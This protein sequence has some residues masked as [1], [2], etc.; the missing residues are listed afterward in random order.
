MAHDFVKIEFDGE[1][2]DAVYSDLVRLEVELDDELAAMFRLRVSMIQTAEG[3][4]SLDDER[5]CIWAPVLITAGFGDDNQELLSGYITHVKPSFGANVEQ[6]YLDV[7]GMD[8][9]VLMDR[10]ENLK[11]W[12]DKTD[13]AIASEIFE[14]YGLDAEVEDTTV[15]H[16]KDAGTTIQ[17]ETDLQ[18]LKRLALR[19]GYEC[20]VQG[21]TGYFK[22]P[23]IDEEPQPVLAVHFGDQTNIHNFSLQVDALAPVNVG[24]F[25]I[26]RLNKEVLSVNVESS[27]QTPLGES[28]A[29]AFLASDMDRGQIYVGRNGATE[30]TEMQALCQGLFHQAEWFVTAHGEVSANHYEH[31]LTPRKTVTVKGVGE[32]YSGVYFVNHVTHVFTSGGYTQLVKMKRNALLPTGAEDFGD[33][34]GLLG[35]L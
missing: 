33:S 14:A 16:D 6:A 11:D 8:A 13:S 21:T 24:M 22:A 2:I 19:N 28:D 25:Q 1:E 5:L 27:L 17:R 3:W 31:V 20:Y 26:D 4:T 35:G 12:P 34:G 7:W 10:V 18:F 15:E 23:V 32:T 9:S 29:G 30:K